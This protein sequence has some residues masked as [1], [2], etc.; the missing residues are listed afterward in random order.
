MVTTLL[1]CG[2]S[3]TC[4]GLLSITS[5]WPYPATA[6]SRAGLLHVCVA[7]EALQPEAQTVQVCTLL[8]GWPAAEARCQRLCCIAEEAGLLQ[9]SRP[10]GTSAV[11]SHTRVSGAQDGARAPRQARIGSSP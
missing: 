11:S 5:P 10:A 8:A 1:G 2:S 7:W 3:V 4:C 9:V 6:A